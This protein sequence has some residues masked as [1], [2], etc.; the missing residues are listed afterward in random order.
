MNPYNDLLS[1]HDNAV[2]HSEPT[3]CEDGKELT[4]EEYLKIS[5]KKAKRSFIVQLVL[6][7][8]VLLVRAWIFMAYPV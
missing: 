3:V 4:L 5:H 2:D 8:L 6:F 1:I 7:Y